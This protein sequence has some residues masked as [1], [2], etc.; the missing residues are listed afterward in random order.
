MRGEGFA[1]RSKVRPS[2]GASGD[3]L[4]RALQAPHP[5]LSREG[6]ARVP[7][8]SG[9]PSIR[10]AGGPSRSRL[11]CSA[12]ARRAG[13]V[14][15]G[16]RRG[17]RRGPRS[18]RPPECRRSGGLDRIHRRIPAPE[19]AGG[20]APNPQNH[21]RKSPRRT[22]R[23]SKPRCRQARSGAERSG[24]CPSTSAASRGETGG[25]R[26]GSP[27]ARRGPTRT[28]S[29]CPPRE[30]SFRLGGLAGPKEGR[31]DCGGRGRSDQRRERIRR[32]DSRSF[33]KTSSGS[34]NRRGGGRR[35]RR[36]VLRLPSWKR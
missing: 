20:E 26:Q 23:S 2:A 17:S 21:T 33:G 22:P 31:R 30:A 12:S 6:P 15:P 14:R 29:Q 25:N 11:A 1:G 18:P 13:A 35:E 16:P 8:S 7:S 28:A 27:G 24:G 36:P 3:T 34:R 19:S 10:S 5:L 32:F 4:L 9:G